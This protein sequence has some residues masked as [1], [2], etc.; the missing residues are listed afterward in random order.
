MKLT[1]NELQRGF[2]S[3]GKLANQD[4]PLKVGYWLGRIAKTAEAEMKTLEDARIKL[5]KRLGE[6]DGE[7]NYTIPADAMEAF[8][9][10]MTELLEVS[11][12]LPGERIKLESLPD[13]VKLSAIDLI[14]LDWLFEV[15]AGAE[16]A[17]TAGA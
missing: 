10:E 16:K 9:A 6:D 2:T 4:L 13:G 3:L 1:L 7:G 14:N 5:V 17:A 12:E 11:I 15:E 8:T